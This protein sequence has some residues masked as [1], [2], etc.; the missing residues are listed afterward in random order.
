MIKVIH[1][2]DCPGCEEIITDLHPIRFEFAVDN[3]LIQDKIVAEYP[4]PLKVSSPKGGF[5]T[6]STESLDFCSSACMLDFLDTIYSRIRQLE[7]ECE[8]EHGNSPDA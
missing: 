7:A 2:C 1:T 6:V 5:A 4:R 8:K 3:A